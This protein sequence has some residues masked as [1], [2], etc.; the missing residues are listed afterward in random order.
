MVEA[1]REDGA[2]G[3]DE[4]AE[5]DVESVVPEVGEPRRRDVDAGEPRDDSEQEKVDWRRGCLAAE[6][7]HG[8]VA[9][10]PRE[11]RVGVAC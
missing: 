2:G 7:G 3:P 5:E 8:I 4:V 6:G 10:G 11:S 1:E 9:V